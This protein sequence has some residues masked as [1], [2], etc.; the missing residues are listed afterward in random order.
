MAKQDFMSLVQ[1]HERAWGLDSYP[2]R[3]K[4]DDILKA[5]IVVFWHPTLRR[6]HAYR[7]SIH[8]NMQ[9]VEQFVTDLLLKGGQVSERRLAYLF[10]NQKE[11][12]IKRVKLVFEKV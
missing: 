7:I 12:K 3:P 8:E 4:L 9:D 11:I 6:D 10:V 5:W 1:L 2:G